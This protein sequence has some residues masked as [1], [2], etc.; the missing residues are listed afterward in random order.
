[1]LFI[2]Y[3]GIAD[4]PMKEIDGVTSATLREFVGPRRAWLAIEQMA[5]KAGLL[6]PS[7]RPNGQNTCYFGDRC[8]TTH[9]LLAKQL[10]ITQLGIVM[11]V[12]VAPNTLPCGGD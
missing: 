12:Y 11:R 5:L 10:G 3:E 4:M 1:M 8:C 9:W 6:D 7:L 2:T